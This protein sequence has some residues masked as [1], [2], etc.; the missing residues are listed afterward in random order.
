MLINVYLPLLTDCL[1][2]ASDFKNAPK[3]SAV[4]DAQRFESG[5]LIIWLAVKSLVTISSLVNSV[6]VN[7]IFLILVKMV[8]VTGLEPVTLWMSFRCATNCAK[9]PYF[10]FNVAHLVQMLPL[11]KRYLIVL[12]GRVNCAK[13]PLHIFCVRHNCIYPRQTLICNLYHKAKIHTI[14]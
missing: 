2:K 6:V 13:R 3:F 1:L 5:F 4:F 10:T 9:R 8:G 11:S 12:F 7:F 14:N